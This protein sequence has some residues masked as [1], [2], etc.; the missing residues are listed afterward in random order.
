MRALDTG[1][2][3][4]VRIALAAETV[5]DDAGQLINMLF[6]NTSL[7]DDVVA[8]RCR[9]SGPRW[10]RHSAGPGTGSHGLRRRVGAGGAGADM[11]GAEAA[12]AA[13]PETRGVWRGA[14]RKAAS[15][16]SRTITASPTRAIRPSRPASAAIADGVAPRRRQGERA[17]CRA[18]PAISTPCAGRS[19]S[20][21][22]AGVDTVMVAPMI[23]GLC[24]FPPAG[25]RASPASPS[26]PIRRWPARRGS[27]LRFCSARCSACS[28]P[29]P[30]C[31]PTTAA[32]SAIRRRPA[33]ARARRA[34]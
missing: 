18:S 1:R 24:E 28:A 7:H 22:S 13:R 2:R 31:F 9:V 16:T 30:W 11:L 14:S 19:R 21:A 15:T 5:G 8:A 20:R 10:S 23:A 32:A 34:R 26:S 27:R 25:A 29:M 33:G 4:E 6:G 17:M 3:F 12:G